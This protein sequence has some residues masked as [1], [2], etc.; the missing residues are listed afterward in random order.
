MSWRSAIREKSPR[1]DPP[2]APID[3]ARTVVTVVAGVGIGGDR[4]ATHRGYWS[5]P[6]W[7][8]R[9][10]TVVES[11]VAEMLGLDTGTLR[12]NIVTRDVRLGDPI[13]VRVAIGEHWPKGCARVICATT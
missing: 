4:Y 6:K 5:D 11:E 2:R 8:D 1:S 12:R 10:L 3:A 13:G 9:G 7:P